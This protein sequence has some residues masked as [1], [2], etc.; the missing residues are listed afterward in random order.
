MD[1]TY[2]VVMTSYRAGGAG[3]LLTEGAGIPKEELESRVMAILPN[4]QLYNI[5]KYFE[6]KGVV[7]GNTVYNWKFIP[8]KWA[9]MGAEKDK[10]F[11]FR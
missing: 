6:I 11:M 7:E 3:G 2:E 9:K 10:E 5:M 4:D 8:E 1:K